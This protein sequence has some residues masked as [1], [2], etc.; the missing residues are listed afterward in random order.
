[1]LALHAQESGEEKKE[2][3]KYTSRTSQ[4]MAEE[5]E[6]GIVQNLTLRKERG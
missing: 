2:G 1:V 3:R 5:D 6:M 4:A